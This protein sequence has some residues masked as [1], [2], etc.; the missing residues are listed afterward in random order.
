MD[1]QVIIVPVRA[2]VNLKSMTLDE[3]S[4]QKKRMHLS[5]F[6][7]LIE[8]VRMELNRAIEQPAALDK[9]REEHPNKVPKEVLESVANAIIGNCEAKLERHEAYDCALYRDEVFFRER[10]TE[11]LDV[12]T[13][14]MSKLRLWTENKRARI[15]DIERLQLRESHRR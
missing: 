14:A 7:L 15:P 10:V 4:G 13:M 6:G 3:F 1:V 5:S 11:M 2:N 12:K 9:C 8:E